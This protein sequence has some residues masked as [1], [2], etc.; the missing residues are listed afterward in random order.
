MAPQDFNKILCMC[1]FIWEVANKQT[2]DRFIKNKMVFLLYKTNVSKLKTLSWWCFTHKRQKLCYNISLFFLVEWKAVDL[3]CQIKFSLSMFVS[4]K[5][6]SIMGKIYAYN[7]IIPP[8][9]HCC[10]ACFFSVLF[11]HQFELK[12]LDANFDKFIVRLH[13]FHIFFILAKFQNNYKSITISSINCLNLSFISLKLYIKN[14]F[15]NQMVNNTRLE[16]M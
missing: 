12:F 9:T 16:Y 4:G 10:V 13:Y 15:I 2:T 5:F 14:K 6:G 8:S 11:F 7:L 3:N 1:V